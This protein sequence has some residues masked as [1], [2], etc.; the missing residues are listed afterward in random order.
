MAEQNVP[1]TNIQI[2]RRVLAERKRQRIAIL[3]LPPPIQNMPSGVRY[4][5]LLS[6]RLLNTTPTNSDATVLGVQARVLDGPS[7]CEHPQ[8]RLLP[9]IRREPLSTFARLIADNLETCAP[10]ARNFN[11]SMGMRTRY[12]CSLQPPKP[13]PC[14]GESSV[15]K[16]P[17][18]FFASFNWWRAREYSAGH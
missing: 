12:G 10:G 9:A 3:G 15:L 4:V 7:H 11:W 5:C 1:T 14:G 8:R 6:L 13:L 2:K 17:R 16:N 18:A